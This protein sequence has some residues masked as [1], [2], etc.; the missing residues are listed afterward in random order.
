MRGSLG[1][2]LVAALESQSLAHACFCHI[3]A[4]TREFAPTNPHAS[5]LRVL[6]LRRVAVFGL[7]RA[8]SSPLPSFPRMESFS[9]IG[10][11]NI[12]NRWFAQ[13]VE[14]MRLLQ[15]LTFEGVSAEVADSVNLYI[16]ALHRLDH[17]SL[18]AK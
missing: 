18:V 9:A 7:W 6:S 11:S 14:S 2:L 10:C 16:P 4:K 15:E 12:V 17:Y 3:S 5:N 1:K 13:A 8:S